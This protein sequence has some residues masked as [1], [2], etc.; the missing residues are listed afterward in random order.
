MSADGGR[1]GVSQS[2][3]LIMVLAAPIADPDSV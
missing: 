3:V 2:Q 1:D